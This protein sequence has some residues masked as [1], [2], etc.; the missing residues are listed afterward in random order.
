MKIQLFL[1]PCKIP[2]VVASL[3][4]LALCLIGFSELLSL[5]DSCLNQLLKEVTFWLHKK[6]PATN[7][8][9]QISAN[10]GLSFPVF[11][12]IIFIVLFLVSMIK[13]DI[14]M[15]A[16]MIQSSDPFILVKSKH[17]WHHQNKLF[18]Q[19]NTPFWFHAIFFYSN[20]T[21]FTLMV[22]ECIN[23]KFS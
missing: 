18:D 9:G 6:D 14:D 7:L 1:M 23:L 13:M 17:F 11:F 8:T 16:I 4:L 22:K 21:L 20:F 3:F 19:P 5:F 2:D 10:V 12:L 15:R